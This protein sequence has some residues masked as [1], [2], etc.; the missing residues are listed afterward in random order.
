VDFRLGEVPRYGSPEAARR[1]TCTFQGLAVFCGPMGL[2]PAQ[3]VLYRNAGNGTFTDVTRQAGLA[4]DPPRYALG[5]V[6]G[7]YDNDGDSDVYVA[8]DSVQNSLWM[9]LGNGTFQDVGVRTLTA[10]SGA[11]QPQ[12]GMGTDFGDYNGDGFLD[13]VVTNFSHDLNTIYRNVSGKFFVDDSLSVGMGVTQMALSWGTAFYD[14][15]LDGDLDLFIAN[16]HTYPHVDDYN[17]GTR[18]KQ[19]NHVFLNESGRLVEVSERSGPGLA[20]E[21]SFRGAA[22]A[23]YD[24]DGD[25]DVFVVAL[26][27]APLLLRNDTPRRGHYLMVRLVG[28]ES[29]RDGVGARVIVTA[30]GRR[31]IR[32]RKGGG[33]YLS[34]S[35]PRLHFG[36]GTATI[37]DAVHV[38]WPSGRQDALREMAADQVLTITEGQTSGR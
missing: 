1:T 25:V 14:F 38:R 34:Q 15:D 23:D 8:N 24:D 16:G 28:R 36:L 32:E 20:I 27:E 31:Q 18:F 13:L 7:D 30:G 26:D 10:L 17:I 22:F 12:A 11:G 35:D 29:N 5:V 21:R 3:D 9:N 19:R 37:V 6:T 4:V 33:S 2:R